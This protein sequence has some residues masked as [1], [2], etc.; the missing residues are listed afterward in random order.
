MK[1]AEIKRIFQAHMS[2]F[3][4]N[5]IDFDSYANLWSDE[6]VVELPYETKGRLRRVEGKE[7]I[8]TYMRGLPN[9]AQNWEFSDFDFT[10]A[11]TGDT[12]FVEF[13]GKAFVP[14]TG[15]AYHQLYAIKIRVENGKLIFYRE[16]RDSQAILDA[17][18][19]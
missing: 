4:P 3:D 7:A 5:P 9:T 15:R 14:G 1:Q 17:F 8:V 19:P 11:E 10:V 16:Y 18:V 13:E 6:A 2:L 12:A